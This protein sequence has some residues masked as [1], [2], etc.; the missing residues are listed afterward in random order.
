[1]SD[2]GA[3]PADGDPASG[4]R[5]KKAVAFCEYDWL[6]TGKPTER[7][8]QGKIIGLTHPVEELRA[9]VSGRGFVTRGAEDSRRLGLHD[10]HGNI[11]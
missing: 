3:K 11:A 9:G 4:V 7:L 2:A 8:R 1:M 5:R 6:N 10:M